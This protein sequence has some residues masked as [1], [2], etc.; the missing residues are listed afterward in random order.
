[1]CNQAD[2]HHKRKATFI[3]QGDTHKPAFT[4]DGE[5]VFRGWVLDI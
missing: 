4:F 3:Y 5:R 1:M 2:L